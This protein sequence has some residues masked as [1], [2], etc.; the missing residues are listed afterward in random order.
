MNPWAKEH[1][2][3]NEERS[4]TGGSK[5]PVFGGQ[6]FQEQKSMDCRGS[7]QYLGNEFKHP[8]STGSVKIWKK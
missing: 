3:S 1:T 4:E 5:P 6:R 7:F 2:E 8:R